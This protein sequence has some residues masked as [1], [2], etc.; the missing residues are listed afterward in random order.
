[1]LYENW[2]L[3]RYGRRV[4]YAT[5]F[6]DSSSPC[7]LLATASPLC[8]HT[9]SLHLEQLEM[10]RN[11]IICLVRAIFRHTRYLGALFDAGSPLLISGKT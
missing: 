10:D 7:C 5:G 1:M 3:C 9:D 4:R 6:A 11:K 8:R 2:D